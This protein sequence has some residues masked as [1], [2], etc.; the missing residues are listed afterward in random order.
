MD[1]SPTSSAPPSLDVRTKFASNIF[2]LNGDELGYVM[3]IIDIRCPQAVEYI[4]PSIDESDDEVDER[5]KEKEIQAEINVDAI[6]H[7]T[8][9]ELDRF[10]KDKLYSRDGVASSSS[11]HHHH[12]STNTAKD[13]MS[14]MTTT[15]AAAS[16]KR[17]K[18][19]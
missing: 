2:R 8:F 16:Q 1:G 9:A 10:V 15:T 12:S 17:R 4:G 3:Q 19:K 7:K 18:T 14:I 11:H 6:D 13:V 5:K